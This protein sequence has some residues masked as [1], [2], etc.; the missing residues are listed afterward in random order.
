M[1]GLALGIVEAVHGV[2]AREHAKSVAANDGE[3]ELKLL[4]LLWHT[5]IFLHIPGLNVS[6]LLR[7]TCQDLPGQYNNATSR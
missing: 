7:H 2:D 4:A 1:D 5:P 6:R 3:E